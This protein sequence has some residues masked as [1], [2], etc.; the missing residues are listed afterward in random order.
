MVGKQEGQ[1][2][3]SL[4]GRRLTRVALRRSKKISSKSPRTLSGKLLERTIKQV[5]QEDIEK[6]SVEKWSGKDLFEFY[7]GA[8][9]RRPMELTIKKFDIKP[10]ILAIKKIG[11]FWLDLDES[12]P[13]ISQTVIKWLENF[14]ID[15]P[16]IQIIEDI[17]VGFK[18]SF[19]STLAATLDISQNRLGQSLNISKRTI[20]RRRTE[21][22]F[23]AEESERIM[24]LYKIIQKALDVF[25]GDV[26]AARLW[27]KNPKKALGGEIPMDFADTGIGA[28]EV[29]HLLG[30]IEHG[31]YS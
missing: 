27:I 18:F 1:T 7:K 13:Q 19:L 11:D 22:K 20:A 16:I 31:V 17:K 3:Q 30:R 29:T 10:D 28:Q 24:R 26:D 6:Q 5:L 21:G 9:N 15:K 2:R 12:N 4:T 8:Q 14:K 23:T 25:D